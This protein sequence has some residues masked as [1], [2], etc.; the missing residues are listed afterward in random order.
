MYCARCHGAGGMPNGLLPDLRA[1]SPE[2]ESAFSDIVLRGAF[3]GKGMP[4][5]SAWLDEAAAGKILGWL[6]SRKPVQ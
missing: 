4:E 6:R 3:R 2:V 1:M 5:F